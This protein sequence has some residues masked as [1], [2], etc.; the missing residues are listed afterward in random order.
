MANNLSAPQGRGAFIGRAM[1][2]FEE[3]RFVRGAG[4]YTD[5]VSVP[6]GTYAASVRA[7]HAHARIVSFYVSAARGHRQL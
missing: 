7:P 5:D 2:R 1:P 6:G 4:N 3:Q